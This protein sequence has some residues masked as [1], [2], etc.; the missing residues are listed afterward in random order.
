M[1]GLLIR[2][3]QCAPAIRAAPLKAGWMV[4]G[5]GSWV[6][7]VG[8]VWV[9]RSLRTS[10]DGEP[11]PRAAN[12]VSAEPGPLVEDGP[13]SGG[14]RGSRVGQ[15]L[16]KGAVPCNDGPPPPRIRRSLESAAFSFSFRI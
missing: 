12:L 4:S 16:T 6:T 10:L 13:A 9:R 7:G 3:F 8:P 15:G 2:S 11:R 5:L 1:T 14:S